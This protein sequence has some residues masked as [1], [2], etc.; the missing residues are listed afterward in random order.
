MKYELPPL[1]SG[2]TSGDIEAAANMSAEDRNQI[3]RGM[4]QNLSDRLAS[5]GGSPEEWARLIAAYGVLG[6]TDQARAIW[7][8]AQ[9]VFAEKPDVLARIRTGAVRAGLAE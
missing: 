2:P 7:T 3:I 6:E 8:E 9:Q 1:P 4:V 5:D